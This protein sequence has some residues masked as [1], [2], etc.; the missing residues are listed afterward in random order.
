MVYQRPWESDDSAG[1][2][3][4]ATTTAA[5]ATTSPTTSS[6]TS[7]TTTPSAPVGFDAMRD[8]VLSVYGALPGDPMSAWAESIRTIRT[9][10]GWNDF[11]GFWSTA[12]SVTVL[13]VT[14]RDAHSVTVRLRYVMKDGR[15]E[16]EDRWLSVV[17]ANGRLLVYDS[18]RIGP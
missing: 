14:P 10:P 16:T 2:A 6:I 17:S 1:P 7:A 9:G 13:S 3:T 8:L 11:V 15:V 18:E 5:T 12:Q 4:T